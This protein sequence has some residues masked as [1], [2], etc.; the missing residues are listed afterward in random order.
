MFWR[1][2]LP[3]SL[4]GGIGFL[5]S[6]TIYLPNYKWFLCHGDGVW[7]PSEDRV[8][9]YILIRS[10]S[11]FLFFSGMI[12]QLWKVPFGS[13]MCDCLSVHMYQGFHWMGVCW[14][15]YW[16]LLKMNIWIKFGKNVGHF[17]WTPLY[18][19]RCC[20]TD[21]FWLKLGVVCMLPKV[22]CGA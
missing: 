5:Q 22:E 1:N 21:M 13:F 8:N 2:A 17:T 6:I 19:L 16:R 11:I 10:T 3:Q 9:K 12:V 4:L 7:R 18:I 14:I 20:C 15:W